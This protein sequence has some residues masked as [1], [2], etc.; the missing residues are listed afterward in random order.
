[1]KNMQFYSRHRE[2]KIT[3]KLVC[4]SQKRPRHYIMRVCR[5][6]DGASVFI[7]IPI[8]IYVY[9]ILQ[10]TTRRIGYRSGTEKQ[11]QTSLTAG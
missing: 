6:F 9:I 4:L 10:A 7:I 11:Q 5:V 3:P 2:F 8:I 1:M